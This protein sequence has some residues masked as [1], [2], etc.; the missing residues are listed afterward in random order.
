MFRH[1]Q[2]NLKF[3]NPPSQPL[4]EGLSHTRVTDSMGHKHT[5]I[6]VSTMMVRVTSVGQQYTLRCSK[7][8]I[9]S[10]HVPSGSED[11]AGTSVSENKTD[12]NVHKYHKEC[13]WVEHITKVG[14]GCFFNIPYNR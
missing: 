4:N 3:I 14:G 2:G 6:R 10:S 5:L 12:K 7:K 1:G 13:P 11:S 9:S 8:R